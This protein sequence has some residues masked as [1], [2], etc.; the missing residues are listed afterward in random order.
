MDELSLKARIK[1]DTENAMRSKNTAELGTLR[2]LNAAIKQ[3][4]VD[5]KISA[6]DEVILAIIDKMCKQ[7]RESSEQFSS[8]GREDLVKQEQFE[9]SVLQR[10]LPPQLD[11]KELTAIIQEA[12]KTANGDMGK[13]MK[14]VKPQVQGRADLS[15]V[16]AKVK[17]LLSSIK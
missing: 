7:R 16:S 10:Y 12:I 5:E 17:V 6:S 14:I 1:Q 13:I 8:A 9:I 4:E 3:R 15:Q 2:M 11:E